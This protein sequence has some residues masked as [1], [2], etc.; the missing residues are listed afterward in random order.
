M[1]GRTSADRPLAGR[2][3]GEAPCGRP[4]AGPSSSLTPPGDG[5][6]TGATMS[7]GQGVDQRSRERDAQA[8]PQVIPFPSSS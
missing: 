3:A 4:P 6:D 5:T 7:E 8:P 1:R 2:M